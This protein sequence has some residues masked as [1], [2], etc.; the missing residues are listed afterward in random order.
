MG[1]SVLLSA[2]SIDLLCK[3]LQQLTLKVITNSLLE[4]CI[5]FFPR[6][7]SALLVLLGDLRADVQ[8]ETDGSTMAT[9][10]SEP[11]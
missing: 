9:G 11:E 5:V 2:D 3:S 10:W 8:E 4:L 1:S 6:D 7:S